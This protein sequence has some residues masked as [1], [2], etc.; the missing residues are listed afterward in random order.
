[1]QYAREGFV[2]A[3]LRTSTS[4]TPLSNPPGPAMAAS[5]R[6]QQ[7]TAGLL[8]PEDITGSSGS[9]GLVA[10]EDATGST[11]SAGLGAPENMSDSLSKMMQESYR[12]LVE[13]QDVMEVDCLRRTLSAIDDILTAHT[14]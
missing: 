12:Q 1:M 4:K 5:Q 6:T 3:S 11:G 13:V 10:S 2:N 14:R 8:A 9:A 7:T